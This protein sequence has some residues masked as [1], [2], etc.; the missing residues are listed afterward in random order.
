MMS[1]A[2]LH[3]SHS[4]DARADDAPPTDGFTD[5]VRE[6]AAE[7]NSATEREEPA[8]GDRSETDSASTEEGSPT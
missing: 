6:D 8:Q 2:P 5:E 7:A 3:H 4:E 1:N